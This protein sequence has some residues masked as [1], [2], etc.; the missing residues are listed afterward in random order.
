ML[1]RP[2]RTED[3]EKRIREDWQRRFGWLPE[4]QTKQWFKVCNSLSIYIM[5]AEV[6]AILCNRRMREGGRVAGSARYD[7]LSLLFATGIRTAKEMASLITAGHPVGALARWRT[8]HETTVI[9]TVIRNSEPFIGER[10]RDHTV[11]QAFKTI[12]G[13]KKTVEQPGQKLPP[14]VGAA[15]RNAEAKYREMLAKHGDNFKTPYGWAT[16]LVERKRP[17][18]EDLETIAGLRYARQLYAT[19]SYSIHSASISLW[20]QADLAQ[21]EPLGRIIGPNGDGS[22]LAGLLAAHTFMLLRTTWWKANDTN[23]PFLGPDY[24]KDTLGK[25]VDEAVD[26]MNDFLKCETNQD[27]KAQAMQLAEALADSMA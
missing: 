25:M 24:L 22:S 21:N 4:N 16:P 18:L 9:L 1:T 3:D 5:R 27:F 23:N 14:D 13:I 12:A 8:L 6:E 26:L 2:T 19:T 7:A 11:V 20:W 10:Y 15:Y 17:T